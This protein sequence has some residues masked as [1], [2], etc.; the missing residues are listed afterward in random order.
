VGSV[1]NVS[2]SA[3]DPTSLGPSQSQVIYTP[4]LAG[5]TCDRGGESLLRLDVM[6]YRTITTLKR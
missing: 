6:M 5:L 3:F 1:P 4:T 2:G